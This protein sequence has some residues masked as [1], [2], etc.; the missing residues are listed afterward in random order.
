MQIIFLILSA[1]LLLFYGMGDW[2]GLLIAIPLRTFARLS[3]GWG[4]PLAGQCGQHAQMLP[5]D[6]LQRKDDLLVH[7]VQGL[8]VHEERQEL[9]YAISRQLK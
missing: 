4:T 1:G 6:R 7:Q 3:P 2:S 5:F 9:L 8:F